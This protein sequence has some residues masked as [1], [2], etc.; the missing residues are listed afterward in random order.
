MDRTVNPETLRAALAR[1]GLTIASAAREI[2]ISKQALHA[3][4][5]GRVSV[6]A[7]ILR[8]IPLVISSRVEGLSAD[9]VRGAIF[10]DPTDHDDARSHSYLTSRLTEEGVVHA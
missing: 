1:A 5:V 10:S 3:V 9:A 7:R 8:D 6:S 2:G 4:I